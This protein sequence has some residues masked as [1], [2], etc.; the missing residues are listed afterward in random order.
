MKMYAS[1]L[2]VAALG[3]SCAA[4]TECTTEDRSRWQDEGAFQK[5]LAEEG[6]QIEKFEVTDGNCYEIYGWDRDRR[7]VEIYFNPVDGTKVKEEVH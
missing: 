5:K 3:A 2:L 6:F 7:K 1:I 4:K